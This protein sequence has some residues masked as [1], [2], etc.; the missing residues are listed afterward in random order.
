[1]TPLIDVVFQMI[2]FFVVTAAMEKDSVHKDIELAH[3]PHG[4]PQT[5]RDLRA[6]TIDVDTTGW[7]RIGT[8]VYD[9]DRLRGVLGEAR[10]R[11]GVDF[12]VI[13][14]ADA[15]TEHIHVSRIMEQAKLAGLYRVEF[16]AVHSRPRG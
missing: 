10:A 9:L 7:P 4:I 14:R 2:I 11:S 16:V 3:A 8:A 13:I 6:V 5:E 15:R 1:M 12:P